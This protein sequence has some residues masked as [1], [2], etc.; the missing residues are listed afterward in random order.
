VTSEPLGSSPPSTT[1]VPEAT[2]DTV[3]RGAPADLI[4]R[5]PVEGLPVLGDSR[6]LVTIVA[7]SDY[8]CPYSARAEATLTRLRAVYGTDVRIV[9][10]ESP[11][12]MH[13]RARPAAI[14]AL[15]AAEQGSFDRMRARLFAGSLDDE[16]LERSAKDLGLDLARFDADRGGAAS[17]ALGRAQALA[18]HLGVHGTPTFFINGRRVVGAQTEETFR[19]VIDERLATAKNLVSSG[20]RPRDVYERTVAAGA[21][22]V[23]ESADDDGAQGCR[24]DG[25]CNGHGGDTPAIG[26]AV[27]QV[28]TDGDISRGPAG[29]KI[30]I[31][32]FADY[33]CPYCVR[34]EST[35][36]AVEQS[37]PGQ[38]RVVFKNLPLPFHTH[39]RPMAKAAWAAGEQGRY[40]EMHDRLF[41]LTS[42]QDDAAFEKLARDLGLDMTRFDALLS[43]S[44]I[45]ARIDADI[46]DANALGVKGTPTFFVNGHRIVGA[47]PA[48]VFEEAIQR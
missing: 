1:S 45:D 26:E 29:A 27:E 21:D 24:G 39:A 7:F 3:A 11:L 30:V 41:G 46:A 25:E 22:H 19:A 6:A 14:A 12:P 9:V 42:G 28:P 8:Q 31:V 23:D 15:A 34:A 38:V 32:E 47:Q 13:E 18:Q 16:A 20:V 37:H 17:V 2:G 48:S 44:A 5:V 43:S 35:L 33:Q 36:V 4:Y 10:A 40:W